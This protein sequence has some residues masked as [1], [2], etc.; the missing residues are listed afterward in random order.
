MLRL[1]LQWA[2]YSRLVVTIGCG[3]LGLLLLDGSRLVT[4]ALVTVVLM[5]WTVIFSWRILQMKDGGRLG[6]GWLAADLSIVCAVLATQYWTIPPDS[7][8]DGSGWMNA[9]VAMTIVTYQWH[10]SPKVG[11]LAT[12]LLVAAYVVGIEGATGGEGGT[13]P[14][15]AIWLPT[16]GVLSR[17][18]YVLL[19]RG[20]RRADAYLAAGDRE[21]AAAEVS[22]AR[23][24]DER[25]HLA[26]LHD[27][28]AATLLMIGQGAVPRGSEWL[29][30]QARRDLE[31]LTPDARAAPPAQTLDLATMLAET[32]AAG[33]VAVSY[34][35]L[36]TLMLPSTPAIAIRDSVREALT[37]VARHA[38]VSEADLSVQH[39]RG[40]LVVE[41]RD[42]GRGFDPA[43]VPS[44]RRGISESIVSRMSRAG[45]LG[46]VSSSPGRGTVV[47]LEWADA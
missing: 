14:A 37:N 31:M 38:S 21:R 46:T 7:V 42:Q 22:R 26:T 8:P 17:G 32:T 29:Q 44:H 20:G 5:I 1:S 33:G 2:A 6:P 10:T 15:P 13:W 16:D 28:A 23:R 11:A 18:L 45:G 27:T 39:D 24:A 36:Q 3:S 41:I 30:Q 19:R 4:A 35:P 12:V 43:E 47:R 25:E 34:S 40:R 9:L